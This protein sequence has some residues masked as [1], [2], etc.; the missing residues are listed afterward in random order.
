MRRPLLTSLLLT[1]LGLSSAFADSL[2]ERLKLAGNNR[3]EIARHLRTCRFH[4]VRAKCALL[5]RY[6]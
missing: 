5:Y 4:R 2:S 1:F 6:S 3:D